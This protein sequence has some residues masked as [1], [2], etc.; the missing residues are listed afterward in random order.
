MDWLT[1]FSSSINA[2]AWPASIIIV[3]LILKKPILELL[4]YLKN[5]K[6][7][8]IQLEFDKGIKEAKNL[9]EVANLPE[10]TPNEMASTPS[11]TVSSDINSSLIIVTHKELTT[12]FDKLATDNP[13]V[14][15]LEAWLLIED[16][17]VRYAKKNNL[18]YLKKSTPTDILKI[19][20]EKNM[21][22]INISEI[23]EQLRILRNKSV[24]E[25]DFNLKPSQAQEYIDLALRVLGSL[26]MNDAS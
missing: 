18:F 10:M 15:I 25:L 21:L 19:L 11:K 23:I 12:Y 13:R 6:I 7:Y 3:I 5:L 26:G 2:L 16:A 20:V 24:H 4:P 8:N 14:A 17:I 9:A 22:S 1:F